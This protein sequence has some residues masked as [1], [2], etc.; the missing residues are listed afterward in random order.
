MAARHSFEIVCPAGK[1]HFVQRLLGNGSRTI[2]AA[3]DTREEA[4]QWVGNFLLA[5]QQRYL[6]APAA[7][8]EQDNA[9]R[10]AYADLRR[11]LA[12]WVS[13]GNAPPDWQAQPDAA[14]AFTVWFTRQQGR[15]DRELP[16]AARKMWS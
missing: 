1:Q 16:A 10:R 3:C 9:D 2:E 12:D 13:A 7:G 14:H 6:L 5:A 8:V 4:E 11:Q 15:D